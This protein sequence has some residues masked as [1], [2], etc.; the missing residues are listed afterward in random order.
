[1]YAMFV[2][3]CSSGAR[4]KM[5]KEYLSD[6]SYSFEKMN[7]ASKACGPLVQWAIAQVHD[8]LRYITSQYLYYYA[9][10]VCRC[11]ETC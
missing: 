9:G 4:E 2:R 3:M 1:M 7:H 10:W 5:Q 6:P 8:S 11:T